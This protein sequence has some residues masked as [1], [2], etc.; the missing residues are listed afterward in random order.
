MAC[1]V[2]AHP[3]EIKILSH[4]FSS[5][6]MSG[7]TVELPDLKPDLAAELLVLVWEL[8]EAAPLSEPHV[9]LPSLILPP[10]V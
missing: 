4:S 10:Q 7:T 6:S 9:L 2:S 5:N 1:H 3:Q 8:D